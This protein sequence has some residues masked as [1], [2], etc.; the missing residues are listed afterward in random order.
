MTSNTYK[1]SSG[2]GNVPD[3]PIFAHTRPPPKQKKIELEAAFAA[4]FTV[5]KMSSSGGPDWEWLMQENVLCQGH[6]DAVK[7]R[8]TD[9][10]TTRLEAMDENGIELCMSAPVDPAI[11]AMTD[12]KQAREN[13]IKTNNFLFEQC[14]NHKGCMGGWASVSLHDAKTAVTELRRAVT[15]LGF[16]GVLVNGFQQLEDPDDI[17]YL[18]DPVLTP[19]WEALVDL[20]VAVYIHPRVSHQRLMYQ[21]HPYMQGAMWGFAPETAT[22]VL[23]LVYS[24][25]F[26]K[27][28]TAR[29]A[30]G[31]LGETLPYMAWRLEHYFGMN[32]FDKQLTL[33][34]RDYFTRNIWITTSGNFDTPSLMCA[35]SVFGVDHV[36]FSIDYP[37]ENMSWASDW[38]ET[39][40]INDVDCQKICY[41]NAVKFLKL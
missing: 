34:L 40:P 11:Q 4:P 6:V 35:L 38:I 28:P 1:L 17:R 22:H 5:P 24:G 20:D 12:P 16:R 21:G 29:V 26:D 8:L 13:A 15:E 36:M 14:Q 23:R 30:V 31:H 19:F 2:Q 9:F 3:L 7:P 27:F 32:N 41:D 25:I 37:F 10:D 39:A 18:D 33:R